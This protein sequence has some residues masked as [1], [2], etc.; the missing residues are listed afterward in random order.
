MQ[1]MRQTGQ[2]TTALGNVIVNMLVHSRFF[3]RELG[4]L[5]LATFLGDDLAAM[6][7]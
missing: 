5:K 1:S 3:E 2:P 6:F 7:N 4:K